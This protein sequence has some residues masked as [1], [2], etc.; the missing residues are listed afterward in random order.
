MQLATERLV[1]TISDAKIGPIEFY[2]ELRYPCDDLQK[3]LKQSKRQKKIT[4]EREGCGKEQK[5]GRTCKVAYDDVDDVDALLMLM[6]FLATRTEDTSY[7]LDISICMYDRND[8]FLV[9]HYKQHHHLLRC[10]LPFHLC[11]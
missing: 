3:T 11:Q 10:A 9:A 2:E 8:S 4:E 7:P 5:R 6:T 1:E